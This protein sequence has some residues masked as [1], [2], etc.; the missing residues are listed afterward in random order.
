MQTLGGQFLQYLHADSPPT[1]HQGLPGSVQSLPLEVLD[2]NCQGLPAGF[3][4]LLGTQLVDPPLVDPPHV[5][6]QGP[7]AD[8]RNTHIQV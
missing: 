8:L 2:R 5:D 4:K 7:L 1:N 6:V 3:Q